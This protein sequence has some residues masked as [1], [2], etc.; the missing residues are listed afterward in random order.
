ML[1]LTRFNNLGGWLDRVGPFIQILEHAP[2][3]M[4]WPAVKPKLFFG[5]FFITA[6]C[7]CVFEEAALGSQNQAMRWKT[8][9]SDVDGDVG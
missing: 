6:F 7:Q 1:V 9:A 3:G 4:G 8:K 2:V 5:F